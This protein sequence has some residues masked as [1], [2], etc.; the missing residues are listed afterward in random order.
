M[1]MVKG[2]LIADVAFKLL[3]KA[4]VELP[5]D[6]MR[7]L[8]E[9]YT[10]E[11]TVRGKVMLGTMIDAAEV[12]RKEGR[13]LCQDTGIPMF[14]VTIG[15]KVK[16][17]GDIRDALARGTEKATREV[18]LRE[19]VVHPLTSRNPG[20]NVGWGV[21]YVWY[22]YKYDADYLEV[23]AAL[24]GG[25]SAFATFLTVIP[26]GVPRLKAVKRAVIDAAARASYACPPLIVGVC[27]G[28]YPETAAGEAARALLRVP[29]GSSN[30]DPELASLEEELLASVN[31]LGVGPAGLGGDTTA[32]A[33]HVEVRG[34]HTALPS[35]A[36]AFSCWALRRAS[37]RIYA[38]G[39]VEWL[40]PPGGE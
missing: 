35:L 22:D 4:A 1:V 39:S 11:S 19:N 10:R 8:K 27:I 7:L 24:R 20:T 21:P 16:V 33:L 38:D 37:A 32:L 36:V 13:P 23:V 9:A 5:G 29:V 25:G 26:S 15:G 3:S 34:S 2:D 28:G 40:H 14:F 17:K 18:P 31:R 12:A 30:P 6:V